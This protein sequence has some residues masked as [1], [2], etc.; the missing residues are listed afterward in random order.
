MMLGYQ[1]NFQNISG[2]PFL[3]KFLMGFKNFNDFLKIFHPGLCH[4]L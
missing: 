3:G 1:N 4:I 2:M